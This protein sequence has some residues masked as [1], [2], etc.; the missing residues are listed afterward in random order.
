MFLVK[1]VPSGPVRV[2]HTRF[3]WENGKIMAEDLS[4][5]CG[6]NLPNTKLTDCVGEASAPKSQ[7]RANDCGRT[8]R[9][10]WFVR[11]FPRDTNFTS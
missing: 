2:F 3:D 7:L 6:I 4:N 10:H 5:A 8:L 11:R 1:H 9:G